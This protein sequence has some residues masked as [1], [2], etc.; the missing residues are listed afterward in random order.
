MSVTLAML[1][2]DLS[3]ISHISTMLAPSSTIVSGNTSVSVDFDLSD[4][5]KVV[6]YG[7]AKSIFIVSHSSAC[8][9]S[10]HGFSTC[11]L[12]FWHDSQLDANLSM[13]AAYAGHLK[14]FLMVRFI[15]SLSLCFNES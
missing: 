1:T 7:T 15:D 2:A 13:F 5:L 9:L 6:F 8:F 12:A 3:L 4:D 10:F 14:S 11:C